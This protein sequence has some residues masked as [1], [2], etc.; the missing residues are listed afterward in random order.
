MMTRN[1]C[2]DFEYNLARNV[3]PNPKAYEVGRLP[4]IWKHAHITPIH[5]KGWKLFQEIIIRSVLISDRE[6]DGVCNQRF[7]CDSHDGS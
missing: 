1:L 4:S 5:N 3:K 2:R 6:N 7:T